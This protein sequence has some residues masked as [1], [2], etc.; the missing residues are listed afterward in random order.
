MRKIIWFVAF[1]PLLYILY[2][3]SWGFE[4]PRYVARFIYE[5]GGDFLGK[6]PN[7]PLKF[8][9]D[10]LGITA[11]QFLIATLTLTPLRSYLHI[12]LL[13]YRRLLGL[14]TFAYAFMHSLFFFIVD[15]EGKVSLMIE[16][17]YK[18]PFVFFGL[19]AFLILFMMALTSHKKLFSKFVKWH[20]LVYLAAVF[21][22]LHYM[23]SQKVIGFDVMMYVGI[24]VGLLVLR[25]LKR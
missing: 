9:A 13:K 11:I 2:K 4:Y 10:L 15:N 25:L 16:D 1:L 22:S 14:W 20:K 24:L 12:N 5:H 23:M 21:I 6:F 18:R 8:F 7:D 19:S 17:A 3:L